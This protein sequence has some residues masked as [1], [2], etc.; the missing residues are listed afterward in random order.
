MRIENP[1]NLVNKKFRHFKGG[2]YVVTDVAIHT[3]T[4]GPMIVYHNLAHP[5][6]SWCRPINMF[7]S[8]VDREK[9]PD[10]SQKYRFEEW[11]CD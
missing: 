7:L 9:Y 1:R 2:I 8:E 5:E 4:N 6:V 11:E 3:E 10:V